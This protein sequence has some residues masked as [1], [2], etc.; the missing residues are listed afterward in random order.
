MSNP[1][2]R[3][4]QRK[5]LRSVLAHA[6]TPKM[7]ETAAMLFI[8]DPS[9]DRADIA[10]AVS[11]REKQLVREEREA[12]AKLRED[13][14]KG[15]LIRTWPNSKGTGVYELRMG[16]DGVVYCSCPAWR[17]SKE[18]PRSCKHMV[19]WASAIAERGA[20]L[21]GDGTKKRPK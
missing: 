5:A 12:Q 4:E 3:D 1:H 6:K 19:A 9:Y 15:E 16:K 2:L 17:F 14:D 11:D 10:E 18:R 20:A 7:I 8:L 21:V 13:E